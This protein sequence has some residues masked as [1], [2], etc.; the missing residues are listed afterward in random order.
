MV[1][2][3]KST[4]KRTYIQ[5]ADVATLKK[6]EKKFIWAR[7]IRAMFSLYRENDNFKWLLEDEYENIK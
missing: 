1:S 6:L 5:K 7:L 2:E 4:E 3:I